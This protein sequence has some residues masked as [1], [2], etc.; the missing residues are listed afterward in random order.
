MAL[1]QCRAMVASSMPKLRFE[2]AGALK[3]RSVSVI[4]KSVIAAQAGIQVL[5]IA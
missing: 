3:R 1:L 5:T 4:L 2:R